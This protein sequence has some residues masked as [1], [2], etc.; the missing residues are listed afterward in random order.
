[1]SLNDLSNGDYSIICCVFAVASCVSITT[2]SIYHIISTRKH[3]SNEKCSRPVY[4]S[5]SLLFLAICTAIN[6]TM[7]IFDDFHTPSFCWY[8]AYV[9]IPTYI[10]YKC[11]MY[12]IL[13]Q[14]IYI[15][16]YQAFDYTQYQ[17][18]TAKALKLWLAIIIGWSLLNIIFICTTLTV[19]FDAN[20]VPKCHTKVFRPSLISMGLLDIIACSVTLYLFVKPIAQLR[21]QISN[22]SATNTRMQTDSLKLHQI[23]KKQCM[24]S[25]IAVLT[26]V[27]GMTLVALF[28]M[29]QIFIGIDINISTV[30]LILM[31][32]WND[33]L[34]AKL[35]CLSII[36][37]EQSVSDVEANQ[38]V[39]HN[40]IRI[41]TSTKGSDVIV[42]TQTTQI[43]SIT[44]TD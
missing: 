29:E 20:K 41:D 18:V 38:S 2:I 13:L 24:L 33:Y 17:V 28:S 16:L 42:P 23:A 14:R 27:I 5:M 15:I 26:T 36:N 39:K 19:S 10:L 11:L 21:K 32:K 8:S 7:E 1:M 43:K 37:S 12:L 35:C 31:Y 40:A 9:A 3:V 6:L 44:V 30:S 34:V 25:T 4:L 22:M